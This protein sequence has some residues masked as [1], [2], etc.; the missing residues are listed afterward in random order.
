MAGLILSASLA[1]AA[2]DGRTS[3][4]IGGARAATVAIDRLGPGVDVDLELILAVDVSDSM[5]GAELVQQRNGYVAAF[6]HPDVFEAIASGPHG[7][8]AVAY[9]EWAGPDDQ[10]LV[11]PWTVLAID[12]NSVRFAGQARRRAAEAGGS[13]RAAIRP[14]RR[15]RP[16]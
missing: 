4:D 2:S 11:L 12:D 1:C 3:G 16:R 5:S 10:W 14:G 8:I 7:R 13:Y 6:R 9:M 15:Y